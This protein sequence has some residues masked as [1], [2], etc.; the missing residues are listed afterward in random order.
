MRTIITSVSL[1]ESE[2]EFLDTNNLSPT[3]LLK[4]KIL[5]I[6]QSFEQ[7]ASK[8]LAESRKTIERLTIE[9]DKRNDFIESEGLVDKFLSI[10]QQ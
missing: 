7:F 10:T 1:L 8:K 2:K 6:Q 5:D 9:C 3:A 4:Q